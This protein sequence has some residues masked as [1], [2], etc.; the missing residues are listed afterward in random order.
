MSNVVFNLKR[1]TPSLCKQDRADISGWQDAQLHPVADPMATSG[2]RDLF[3]LFNTFANK[4]RFVVGID[5]RTSRGYLHM[6]VKLVDREG[7]PPPP[8]V[9]RVLFAIQTTQLNMRLLQVRGSI[10]ICGLFRKT[11]PSPHRTHGMTQRLDSC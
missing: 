8:S 3:Y 2:G 1:L 11:D 5:I 6:G 10:G 7:N 4:L 9:T